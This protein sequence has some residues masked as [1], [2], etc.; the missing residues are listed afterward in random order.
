MEWMASHTVP[1]SGG[2]LTL[3]YLLAALQRPSRKTTA[4]G[5]WANA[6]PALERCN[7]LHRLYLRRMANDCLIRLWKKLSTD[8]L[9]DRFPW[10]RGFWTNNERRGKRVMQR[11][12]MRETFRGR[13][14]CG[15]KPFCLLNG[16][17]TTYCLVSAVRL[18]SLG[19][20][21]R[22]RRYRFWE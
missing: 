14:R 13:R 21:W 4:K 7:M 1:K 15:I 8:K 22:P 5:P 11:Q 2:A 6:D 19:T 16:C 12:A 20:T 3:H 18:I 17:E 9:L 10:K